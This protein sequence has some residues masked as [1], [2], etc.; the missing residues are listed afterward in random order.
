MDADSAV[1][2][3]DVSESAAVK[4]YQ[5]VTEQELIE[6]TG[7]SVN[8]RR[9]FQS[10]DAALAEGQQWANIYAATINRPVLRHEVNRY[11]IVVAWEDEARTV[12]VVV[13]EGDLETADAAPVV[14]PPLVREKSS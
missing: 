10:R 13:H 9:Y 5:L 14:P 8:D 11:G 6:G 3:A 2:L 12:R 7:L 4:V 1:S